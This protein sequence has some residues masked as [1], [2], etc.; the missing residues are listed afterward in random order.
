MPRKRLRLAVSG[1]QQKQPP[2]MV[3]YADLRQPGQSAPLPPAPDLLREISHEET[4]NTKVVSVYLRAL[5]SFVVDFH[6]WDRYFPQ[7]NTSRRLGFTSICINAWL[8][9]CCGRADSGAA[10]A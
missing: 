9:V 1:R 6:F 5:R 3:R 8:S 4:K 2:S 7:T 10:I